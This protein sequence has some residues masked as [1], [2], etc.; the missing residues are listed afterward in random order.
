[1]E[2]QTKATPAE[3]QPGK[4]LS[5]R[6]VCV[7]CVLCLLMGAVLILA[8]LWGTF[9]REGIT[10][11]KAQHLIATH[12]VGDYDADQHNQAVLNTMVR[13]LGDRWSYYLTPE[14]YQQTQ[15]N[16]SNAYVGI[17]ITIRRQEDGGLLITG[18]E[19][20][21]SGAQAGLQT[22]EI[23]RGVNGV[24]LTP[25]NQ[26]DCLQKIKGELGS[27]VTLSAE[28]TDGAVRTLT[29]TRQTVQKVSVHWTMLKGNVGL[30]TIENF[31][32]GTGQHLREG[33]EALLAQN[34]RA[35]VFDVRNN[36]GGYVTE[37]TDSLDR[38]LPEGTIFISRKYTGKEP[39][40]T[41][42]A[43]CVD[44]PMAV[45][46]NGDSYSAAE[47]FAAE[48]KESAGAVVAGTQTS[49][50]GFSQMLYPLPDGSAVNLSTAR[51]FTG[52]GVSLIGTG[53]TPDPSVELSD[54]AKQQLLLGSLPAEE[55][56]QLQAAIRAMNLDQ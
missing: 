24:T 38:L 51:Y 12:Y 2:K 1:M 35:L 44:L 34:A 15:E 53:L 37:L 17:G 6:L 40:Y 56:L 4:Q 18:V 19:P 20:G 28:G 16:R 52:N 14:E 41:S 32:I 43:L 26:E 13:S 42:D 27:T 11:L 22:G 50:K 29:V 47:F 36:P 21:S 25:E 31:Y 30:L 8:L 10:L 3:K 46:V 5:L 23:L 54:A 48:L 45:L 55:D 49:G 7:L 39:V 33:V 9:G